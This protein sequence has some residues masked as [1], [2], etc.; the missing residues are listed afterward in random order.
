MTALL[1]GNVDIM[2]DQTTNTTGQIKGGKVKVPTVDGPVMLGH[3]TIGR[4]LPV[5]VDAD[6]AIARDEGESD[7]AVPGGRCE[8]RQ[9][10]LEGG[11]RRQISR[12]AKL[13]LARLTA[14]V[15]GHLER[16][17]A[18]LALLVAPQHPLRPLAH[19]LRHALQTLRQRRAAGCRFVVGRWHQAQPRPRMPWRTSTRS[20][21]SWSVRHS[22]SQ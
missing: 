6:E 21:P 19:G 8:A 5:Q 10:G 12:A 1:G 18:P 3:L 16:A 7:A 20:R 15:V 22:A 11:Q 17:G 2:C 13:A 9:H 4:I 14:D